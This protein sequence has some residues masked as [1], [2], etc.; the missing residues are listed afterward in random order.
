PPE[1]VGSVTGIVGA[2]GGMGGFFPPMVMGA[3]YNA[4]EHSYTIGLTLLVV[5]ATCAALFTL[6]G[7]K[8][9]PVPQSTV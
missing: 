4:A 6:F 9:K 5:F 3:T 7:I 2:A 8:R 1:R